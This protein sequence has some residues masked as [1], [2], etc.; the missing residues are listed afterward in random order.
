MA[1]PLTETALMWTIFQNLRHDAMSGTEEA[2]YSQDLLNGF[3]NNGS[4]KD[5]IINVATEMQRNDIVDEVA[6]TSNLP[7]TVQNIATDLVADIQNGDTNMLVD[8]IK[9]PEV[10]ALSLEKLNQFWNTD[11]LISKQDPDLHT[12][13]QADER[14]VQNFD[15]YIA[16][17]EISGKKVI[18]LREEVVAKHQAAKATID[19]MEYDGIQMALY[20]SSNQFYDLSAK[21]D[22]S[23]LGYTEVAQSTIFSGL[24]VAE[25]LV[26]AELQATMVELPSDVF[27]KEKNIIADSSKLAT[28]PHPMGEPLVAN[29]AE[30]GPLKSIWNTITKLGHSEAQ[31]KT[32]NAPTAEKNITSEVNSPEAQELANN[33]RLA[34]KA[35]Q[36]Y[37][38]NPRALNEKNEF[39]PPGGV[40]SQIVSKLDT[41]IANAEDAIVAYEGKTG[42]VVALDGEIDPAIVVEA[43]AEVEPAAPVVGNIQGT[44]V[45]EKPAATNNQAEQKSAEGNI[46][47][48]VNSPEAQ[49]LANNYL[50]AEQA[51]QNYKLNP[52]ALNEKNEFFP[53][54]GV[55]SQIVSKLDTNIANAEDAIVAYEGKTETTVALDGE[56]DP[57][58]VAEAKTEVEPAAPVAAK[59]TD[60]AT[61]KVAD[62]KT[63]TI[64]DP[65]V[66]AESVN[67]SIPLSLKQHFGGMTNADHTVA[68]LAVAAQNADDP[69]EPYIVQKGDNLWKIAKNEYG[70][71]SYKD[72]MR[73]VDHIAHANGLEKGVDA[74]WIR[75]GEKIN[76]PSAEQIKQPV[77]SLNWKALRE[78]T[79]SGEGPTASFHERAP[80]MN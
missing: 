80:A 60:D 55:S 59:L 25:P 41:N 5:T 9:E 69:P 12:H 19:T 75:E 31:A 20:A 40:S 47:S 54:G 56:I 42:T 35:L 61:P 79:L 34:E 64:V 72:I 68:Q 30:T 76:M 22:F 2:N 3:L 45:A 51:L 1:K 66:G 23:T 63:P 71:T 44:L 14:Y 11:A 18:S 7:T 74:N 65:K 37:K 50:L 15:A 67:N 58:I 26:Q 70:L 38:L 17:N 77:D 43:K 48:E 4:F 13:T 6:N 27:Q 62:E 57:A 16:A 21:G 52:R 73:T 36:D 46:T 33:H 29:A 8:L 39:F 28:N 32:T 24:K 78:N 49:E 10:S 53:P